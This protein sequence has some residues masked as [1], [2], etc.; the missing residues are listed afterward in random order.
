MVYFIILTDT[1]LVVFMTLNHM[2]NYICVSVCVHRNGVVGAVAVI[3]I[4]HV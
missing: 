4:S 1:C 3:T 2:Y